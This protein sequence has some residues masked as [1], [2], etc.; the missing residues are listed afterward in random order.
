MSAI[1]FILQCIY[2]LLPAY[3]ANMAPVIFRKWFSFLAGPMDMG[4]TF[5]G[6]PILGKN[7]TFRGLVTGIL[8]GIGIAF[9]QYLI[10][11]TSMAHYLTLPGL[12]YSLWLHIGFLL[13]AGAIIGDAAESFFKRQIG[14]KP[15]KP[16]I[17]FDQTDFVIGS[18]A[19]ISL[20]Y[21]PGWHIVAAVLIL[22]I[23][24]HISFN[25]FAFWLR[26]RDEKW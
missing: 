11:N 19:F 4:K 22:S 1:Q 8:T 13:G 16:F 17:P 2:F 5:R 14:I 10:R 21:F 18:L 23:I 9:I 25:H 3:F 26:I 20:V 15:G 12:D 6:K 7:K 24:L